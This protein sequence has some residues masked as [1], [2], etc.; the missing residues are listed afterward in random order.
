M[1]PEALKVP[2]VYSKKLDVF[3]SG[4]VA[5][6]IMTRNFPDPG[7]PTMEIEIE[8][9]QSP[10]GT[11]LVPVLEVERRKNHIDLINPTHSL[12]PVALDCLRSGRENAPLHR[13]SA[14]A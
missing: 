13:S 4:V 5:V 10:F 8:D 11:A 2:P 12:L 6:Q 7:P 3:S 9:T 14:I 1:P